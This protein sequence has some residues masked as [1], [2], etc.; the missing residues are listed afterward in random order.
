MEQSSHSKKSNSNS[1]LKKSSTFSKNKNN[2]QLYNNKEKNIYYKN[3][4][5]FSKKILEAKHSCTPD[6]YQKIILNNLILRKRSHNLAY[7]NELAI[8][9]NILKELLKRYYIYEESKNR[10]PKYVSYYQNYL[11][12]FCKPIINDYYMNKKMV[13]HMEKVAQIFYNENYAD[14]EELKESKNPKCNFKIFSKSVNHEI[15]NYANFTKVENDS[16]F[17]ANL[18]YNKNNDNKTLDNK[19]KLKFRNNDLYLLENIYKIT[20]I[21]DI[22]KL[23][24]KE[25]KNKN[26]LSYESDTKNTEM[27]SYQK[28]LNEINYKKKG[29]SKENIF[30]KSPLFSHNSSVF[31]Y[32]M[33]FQ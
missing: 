7:L 2:N 18:Q 1:K 19:N 20:P 25:D 22:N 15:D 29:K 6:L 3:L 24:K 21:L 10:V 30:K 9:T 31:D 23:K 8:N 17:L 28:I 12:F 13:K 14:E 27:N 33:V 16:K 26:N 32:L 4:I 5:F 11:K